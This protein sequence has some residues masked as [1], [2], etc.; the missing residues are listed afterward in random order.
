MDLLEF[1]LGAVGKIYWLISVHRELAETEIDK[2]R[3]RSIS[4]TLNATLINM[5]HEP[6]KAINSLDRVIQRGWNDAKVQIEMLENGW[7]VKFDW[8]MIDENS[9][10]MLKQI[11]DSEGFK[12]W[13]NP[14]LIQ[15][16]KERTC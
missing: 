14:L 13:L 3:Q 4:E 5:M 8:L 7:M 15:E 11:E 10:K 16:I 2:I 12:E 1:E 6:G 9:N